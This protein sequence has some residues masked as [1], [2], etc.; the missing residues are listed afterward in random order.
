M[1]KATLY[2][3]EPVHKAL[4]LKAA[5]T[6]QSMSELVNEALKVSLLEDLEDLKDWR[7]RKD[8]E[9]VGYEAFV[10][11]LMQDGTI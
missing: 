8:D 7:E 9:P 2:L 4:R 11:L 1:S 6:N 3:E 10:E 5:E